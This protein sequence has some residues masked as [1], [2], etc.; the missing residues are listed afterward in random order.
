LGTDNLNEG[1][2]NGRTPWCTAGEFPWCEAVTG[3]IVCWTADAGRP[4]WTGT[5]FGRYHLIALLG[6][7]GMGEVWRAHDTDR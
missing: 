6:E 7:G 5:P 2:D 1:K 4:M 3:L